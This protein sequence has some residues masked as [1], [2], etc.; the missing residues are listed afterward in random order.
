M[1]DYVLTETFR[2]RY[3]SVKG[4]K[5]VIDSGSGRSKGFGFVRFTSEEERDRALQEMN[6][7]YCM[8]RPMRISIATPKTPRGRE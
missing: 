4:A 7:E 2:Q 1:T 3:P 5:V 8:S 6:G